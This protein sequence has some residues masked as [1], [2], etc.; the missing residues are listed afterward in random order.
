MYGNKRTEQ[1]TTL[2]VGTKV[3]FGPHNQNNVGVFDTVTNAFST[4][5]TTGDAATGHR[6]Y[7]GLAV[8]G[9]KVIFV[10]FVQTNVGVLDTTTMTFT[11]VAIPVDGGTGNGEYRG[12]AALGS[13]V[14]FAPAA[15]SSFQ[16]TTTTII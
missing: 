5:P 9:A 10:P 16:H 12:A 8:V 13:K 6:K 14:Y 4:I 3:Y 2:P 7:K 11:T 15:R 1:R